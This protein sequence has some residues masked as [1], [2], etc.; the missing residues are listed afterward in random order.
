[1][2]ASIHVFIWELF[3]QLVI[4]NYLK[5]TAQSPEDTG[6]YSTEKYRKKIKLH[7]VPQHGFLY[8]MKYFCLQAQELVLQNM[9]NYQS[10]TR[11]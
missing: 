1:M 10:T 4:S 6:Q 11:D 3:I 2:I 9:Q 5:V 7:Y 8:Q